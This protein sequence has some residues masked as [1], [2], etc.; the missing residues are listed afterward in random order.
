MCVFLEKSREREGDEKG[1]RRGEESFILEAKFM[2]EISKISYV[3]ELTD[4]RYVF[5]CVFFLVVGVLDELR[6][7]L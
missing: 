1:R 6:L 5:S 4:K 7:W 3:Q 2:G